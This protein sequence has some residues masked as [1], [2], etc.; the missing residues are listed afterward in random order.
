MAE[1]LYEPHSVRTFTGKYVDFK[2][3][4]PDM[5]D[6]A[7]IAHALSNIPRFGGHLPT[8]YSVA[9]HSLLVASLVSVE[10]RFDALM[11]DATEAYLMDMP[12]PLKN[13]L[14]DY[15]ELEGKVFSVLAEKFNLSCPVPSEVK[16]ADNEALEMEWE[17][18]MIEILPGWETLS[19]QEAE[20]KYL[21][22]YK[23]YARGKE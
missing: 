22:E 21:L 6:I 17:R 3:P 19:R 8:W 16:V 4:Q 10:F 12:K 13:L 2:N 18:L 11:H 1:N 9:D 23:K 15:R 14:P 20:D 7:D 5:F